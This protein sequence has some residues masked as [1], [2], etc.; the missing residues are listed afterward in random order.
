MADDMDIEF[1]RSNC[2]DLEGV[3]ASYSLK[4]KIRKA[5]VSRV[6]NH[7][8]DTQLSA[9][10]FF[11]SVDKVKGVDGNDRVVLTFDG[12]DLPHTDHPYKS[13]VIFFAQTIYFLWHT[14]DMQQ[15]D[16]DSNGVYIK[17]LEALLRAVNCVICEGS[18]SCLGKKIEDEV[19]VSIS[20]S[21]EADDCDYLCLRHHL[22][23]STV[24]YVKVL[25]L[26]WDAQ[27]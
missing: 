25:F 13:I 6:V 21:T 3:S 7:D 4:T 5:S 27:L 22:E 10:D 14:N 16:R 24:L 9:I 23:L 19:S 11:C 2:I 20:T 8:T 26:A 17:E 15:P 12:K 18:F 1:M